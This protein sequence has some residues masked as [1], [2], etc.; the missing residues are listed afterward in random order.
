MKILVTGASGQLGFDVCRR[1][2]ELSIENTGVDIADFDLTH[3]EQVLSYMHRY[4]PGCVV[5]CAAYTAVDQAE[6]NAADC[7]AVN[8]AGTRNLAIGCRDV[9]ASMIYISTDY[10]FPGTGNS[11]FETN[12]L[13]NP[14]GVYG[15]TKLEG[16]K[17][18]REL[19]NRYFI[20]RTSWV[21]GVHG[22]NFV[23]TMLRLG[24][25]KESLNVVCDQVGSPTYTRDL[26]VLICEMVQT[27]QYGIY[28][29]T[30]EGYCSWSEFAQV[31]MEEANLECVIH[32]VMTAEYGSPAQR[33]L[34]SRLSKKCLDDAG[35]A[36]LPDWHDALRRYLAE[37][38]T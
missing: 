3:P 35:F 26:A 17:A 24:K 4:R 7:E 30:N 28:H 31:I 14:L 18:I 9:D 27:D 36:R 21:F 22:D 15:R 1:L 10:V 19:L 16:E 11:A 13:K 32:P 29:G 2:N 23:K 25:E 38:E 34:N 37:M 12:D 20:V 6:T 33:P 8:A 5:H